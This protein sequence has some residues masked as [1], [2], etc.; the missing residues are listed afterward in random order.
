MGHRFGPGYKIEELLYGHIHVEG[1]IL[2]HIA[3][4]AAHPKTIF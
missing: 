2:G 4:R 3:D 1:H